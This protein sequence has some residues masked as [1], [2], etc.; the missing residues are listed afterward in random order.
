MAKILIVDD[1][2]DVCEFAKNFFTKR[3]LEVF[4]AR[5]GQDAINIMIKERPHIALLDVRMEGMNGIETLERI[6]QLD[7]KIKV[8]MVTG[9]EEEETAK[10]AKELGA[11]DYIHK[12][13]VLDELEK[14]V[15]KLAK[16]VKK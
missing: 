12:P 4:C 9:V 8:I 2:L 15:M 6:R 13:L 11:L 1:E 3:G 16:R 10:R 5:N 7:K 14:T